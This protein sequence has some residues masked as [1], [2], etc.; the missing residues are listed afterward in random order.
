MNSLIEHKKHNN[1]IIKNIPIEKV[2]F[3]NHDNDILYLLINQS[4]IIIAYQ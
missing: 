1:V 4:L 3:S 2:G